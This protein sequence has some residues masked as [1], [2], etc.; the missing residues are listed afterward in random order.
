MN[1]SQRVN[2]DNQL[3]EF[4]DL[5]IDY[6]WDNEEEHLA[7]VATAKKSELIDWAKSIRQDASDQLNIESIQDSANW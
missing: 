1:A 4:K 2:G 7:W 5:L 3:I 6:E